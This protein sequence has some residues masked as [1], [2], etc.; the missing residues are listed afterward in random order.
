MIKISNETRE[1]WAHLDEISYEISIN[2]HLANK[3]NLSKKQVGS[4][5]EGHGKKL[6]MY[7]K[8]VTML[9]EFAINGFIKHTDIKKIEKFN[10]DLRK[11]E[12]KTQEAWG[13][14]KNETYHNWW[15]TV[16]GCNCPVMDNAERYGIEGNI[17]VDSC[18]WHGLEFNEEKE[19]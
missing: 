2:N 5:F 6:F 14:E 1:E 9:Q 7:N 10:K 16:P 19:I 15:L 18:P 4:V 3:M 12:F 8:A 13:F 17:H 11:L